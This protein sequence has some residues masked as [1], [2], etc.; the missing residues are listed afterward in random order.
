MHHEQQPTDRL[1]FVFLA[2]VF[3]WLKTLNQPLY[4]HLS[5]P[6]AVYRLMKKWLAVLLPTLLYAC[7]PADPL[8]RKTDP[9]QTGVTFTNQLT[10]T[11][12]ENILTFEYFY[13]GGGVAT[14]DFNND[15]RAD[16]F[17]TGNQVDN[18]LYLN[19][20][21]PGSGKLKFSDVSA[22]AGITGRKGGT[23]IPG[24]KTGVTLADVNADGWLDVYVC[25]SG[26]R[27]AELRRNQLFV[28]NHDLTFTDKATEYGLADSGYSVQ[29]TFFDYDRDGDLDCFLINHNLKG[30]QRK[31][32][33]QMRAERDYDAGDKLFRNDGGHF[34]DVSEQAGIKGNPLG[35]G[36]GVSVS[37]VNGDGWPD[38][39]VTN[40]YV[41]DD[42]LYINQQNGKFVDELRDRIGH[43]SYSAM[44]VDVA[45][46]N[47]DS[48]PD[49]FTLDMLPED[50]ARQKLLLWPDSWNVY[51]AQLANGFWHQNM[52]NMLQIQQTSGQFAEVGQLAGVSNTDWS[53]GTLLADFDLDGQKDIFVTNGLGRDFTNADFVKYMDDAEANG[54]GGSV[55]EHLKRMPSTP[56]K[57]YIFQNTGHATFANR[58]REW[59]FDDNTRANGCAYA[60]LDNDGD[61]DL[62]TNNLNEPAR[63]YQNQTRERGNSHFLKLHLTGSAQNPFGVGVSVQ[64]TGDS[65]TQT[66]E[67]Y[68]TRGFE[69]CSYGDLLFGV[70]DKPVQLTVRWPDGKTQRIANVKPDQTRVL[71]YRQATD[72]PEKPTATQ[73]TLFQ[74][75]VGPAFSHKIAPNNNFERQLLLPMHYTYAGP[76]MATGDVNG[77]G[78]ADVFISGTP[79]SPGQLFRQTATGFVNRPLPMPGARKNMDAVLADFNGD[80]HP[81]LYVVNG[82]YEVRDT[83]QLQDQLWLNDGTGNL[84]PS[85]LPTENANGSCVKAFDADRDGDL[86]LF[87]GGHCVP[88]RYPAVAESFILR[89][90]GHRADGSVNF[91]KRSLGK[92]GL[93]SDAAVVDIDKDGW[94]DLVVVG[95]WMPVTVLLN[96]KGQFSVT[97]QKVYDN[98]SGWWNRIE[99]A[100]IDHD[101]DDD[102]IVGNMGLNT[103]FRANGAEPATM[104]YGDFDNNGTLDCFTNYFIQGKSYPACSRDEAGEQVTAL[105]KRFITYQAYA[106]AT[107]EDFFDESIRKNAST[108]TINELRTLVLEN[109]N[110]ELIPHELPIEAQY[111]PVYSVLVNDFDHDGKPDLLLAGNNDH[112][113]LRMGKVDANRGVILLNQGNW[114][115][116]TVS[117]DRT[118]L[119]LKGEVRDLKK[120]GQY[121]FVGIT[122]QPLQTFLLK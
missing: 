57:N 112:L 59:G 48:R 38:I 17:F 45:D 85:P 107:F 10:E 103:Q 28:N 2:K 18:K 119:G 12:Q 50:N 19:Q 25:Y 34:T 8:F 121:V 27:P 29:A 86:D 56:T 30:Y 100:D 75:T 105:R 58:Q 65:A 22:K 66:Q 16:L 106:G 98:L 69:S 52:R 74:P 120:V 60:D 54:P 26:L 88:G 108:R 42:Y 6:I 7:Q 91:T 3:C 80:K 70:A 71:N 51:Q 35:F 20:T 118:G 43:T 76:R 115:F 32:A 82:G 97:H 110:G 96:Q 78:L 83:M 37:D 53:W 93:V 62:I 9:A 11:D 111:A 87:V 31:E 55:S 21:E 113:R 41:E 49:I 72:A 47:N 116:T 63:I 77:D 94:P 89:N 14:G 117:P 109:R 79:E 102:L 114:R 46:V 23:S 15:G 92:L 5:L 122:N 90:D 1:L 68:P 81:D 24:W 39:Y 13:N 67:F 73:P 95:E 61:L 84:K 99:K 40:D 36:L 4:R 104:T 101:G 64:V 33:A 44:G